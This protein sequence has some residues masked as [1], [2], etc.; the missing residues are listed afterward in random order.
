MQVYLHCCGSDDFQV[1]NVSDPTLFAG[2]LFFVFEFLKKFPE[3][4]SMGILCLIE[5]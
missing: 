3:E 4:F 5:G 2:A 1:Y